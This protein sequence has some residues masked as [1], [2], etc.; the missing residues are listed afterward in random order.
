M[1][2]QPV[3]MIETSRLAAWSGRLGIFAVIA[4]ALSAIIVRSGLLEIVPAL[5]TFG[6]A[7]LCAV[8]AIVL[9]LASAIPIWR[10]GLGGIGRAVTGSLLGILL[11]LYPAYLGYRATVLP[12]INDVVTSPND[13]PRFSVLE[14]LRPRGTSDYPGAATAELQRKAYPAVEPLQLAMTPKAAFDAALALVNKRKWR[15]VDSVAPAPGRPAGTIEAIARTT[16]M[17]FRDDVVI[18]VRPLGNATQ[19][20]MRSASRFGQ[21]DF[22]ANAQRVVDYLADLEAAAATTPERRRETPP[23]KPPPPAKR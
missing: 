17:G 1:L 10:R 6:A 5:A 23:K 3:M 8:L 12:K 13:P 14:R 20:D 21:H 15:I 16:I 11:L 22:G 4:A 2:R 19:V 7:L 18:R 9:A